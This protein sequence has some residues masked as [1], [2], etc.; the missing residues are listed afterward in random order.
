MTPHPPDSLTFAD[1]AGPD[2]PPVPPGA[3][4]VALGMAKALA[5]T[6][7]GGRN[8]HQF[9][10][11]LTPSG[12]QRI[13]MWVRSNEGKRT[14]LSRCNLTMVS[15]HVEG[16]LTFKTGERILAVALRIDDLPGSGWVCSQL[17]VLLPGQ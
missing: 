4:S 13:T 9:A 7:S 1:Y 16:W 8:P 11:W 12:C 14:Q 5:E 10:R 17:Q 6:L 15:D 3:Q 2:S